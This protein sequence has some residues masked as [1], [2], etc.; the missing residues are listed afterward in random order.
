MLILYTSPSRVERPYELVVNLEGVRFKSHPLF[1]EE[2][3]IA[4]KL[5]EMGAQL[6][7]TPSLDEDESFMFRLRVSVAMHRGGWPRANV[8][9]YFLPL[10]L[11]FLKC[12]LEWGFPQNSAPKALLETIETQSH[13]L[14]ATGVR[15]FHARDVDGEERRV[16]LSKCVTHRAF[17]Y[18]LVVLAFVPPDDELIN[19]SFFVAA[20]LHRTSGDAL[21]LL[22]Q[23]RAH[24]ATRISLTRNMLASWSK[25][26][27]I[28]QEQVGLQQ[29]HGLD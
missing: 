4:S 10:V 13:G 1:S 27:A 8:G 3:A 21:L 5:A 26:K 14:D 9:P 29:W 15:S 12:P 24:S 11:Y 7:M 28:R 6:A 18:V 25:L 17:C 19:T 2:Q 16:L 23:R 22:G 20:S